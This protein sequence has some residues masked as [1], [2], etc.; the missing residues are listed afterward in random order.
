MNT[1]VLESFDPYH[2]GSAE[3]MDMQHHIEEKLKVSL[4]IIQIRVFV[5]RNKKI[6]IVH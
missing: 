1:S 6:F 3:A 2:Q 5:L 4:I